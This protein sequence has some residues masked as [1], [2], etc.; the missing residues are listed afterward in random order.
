MKRYFIIAAAVSAMMFTQCGNKDGSGSNSSHESS[1]SEVTT[2]GA[3][4]ERMDGDTTQARMD[5]AGNKIEGD[6]NAAGDRMDA[7]GN[8]MGSDM[9]AAGDAAGNAANNAA[10]NAAG[11]AEHVGNDAA[12][13]TTEVNGKAVDD[14]GHRVGHDTKRI[15][16]ESRTAGQKASDAV[17][18]AGNKADSAINGKR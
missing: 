12:K 17:N 5:A 13:V 8:K 3:G 9:N 11:T 2:E 6:M 7:A 1:E 10:N 15:G 4:G 14:D 16:Q 18:R